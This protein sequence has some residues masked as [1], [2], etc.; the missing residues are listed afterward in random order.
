MK[1]SGLSHISFGVESGSQKILNYYRKGTTIEQAVK[2]FNLCKKLGIETFAYFMIGAPVETRE[3]L[4]MTYKLIK[5]IKP[6]GLEVYTTTPYP[7]NDLYSLVKKNKQLK[8]ERKID[9]WSKHSL[10]KLQYLTDM[11]LNEY[12]RKIYRLNNKQLML[13]YFTSFKNFKNLIKYITKRP[14]F[15]INYLKRSL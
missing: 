15:V 11:D 13:R 2:A 9:Y 14:R 6:G 12:R 1:E 7:G 5:R 3:D 8:T 10:I 4:E